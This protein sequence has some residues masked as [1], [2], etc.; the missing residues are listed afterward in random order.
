MAGNRWKFVWVEQE[1]LFCILYGLYC[2]FVSFTLYHDY[3]KLMNNKNVLINGQS[4]FILNR[5]RR[6]RKKRNTFKNVYFAFYMVYIAFLYHSHYTTITVNLWI[7]KMFLLMVKVI[8]FLIEK[9]ERE[10]REIPSLH[11]FP[12]PL[13]IWPPASTH[14]FKCKSCFLLHGKNKPTW[15]PMF[16]FCPRETK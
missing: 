7:T 16:L 12:W 6:E 1:C 13:L 2:F 11:F 8:L 4:N 15:N 10:K 5:K 3:C 14:N 9:G